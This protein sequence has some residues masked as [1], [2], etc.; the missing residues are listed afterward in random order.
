MAAE[1]SAGSGKG[2]VLPAAPIW[3]PRKR[4]QAEPHVYDDIL[5]ML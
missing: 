1:A 4:V 5:L 2:S 3:L